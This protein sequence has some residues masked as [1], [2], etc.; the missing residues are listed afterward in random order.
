MNLCL[1]A[2]VTLF[3]ARHGQTE[4]NRA[5]RFSGRLDTPMT[6]KGL[7]QAHAVGEILKREVGMR[8]EL[9]FVSSPLARARRTMQIVRRVLGLPEDGFTTDPRIQE[10]D[11]GEWDLLTDAEARAR[12]PGLFD[13]RIADKWNVRVPGGENYQDVAARA[14]DWAAGIKADTFAVSHGA[15]SR[16]LRGLLLGLSWQAMTNLDEPQGVVFR[17]RGSEVVRLDP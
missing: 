9:A 17:I 12:D 13:A 5:D 7:V 16:I 6:E 8:P 4:A 1:R 14:A 11:L 15:L 10:I 3:L 2:G